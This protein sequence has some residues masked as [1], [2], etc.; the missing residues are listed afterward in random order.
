[1][2]FENPFLQPS[3]VRQSALKYLF[4]EEPS[5]TTITTGSQPSGSSSIVD[6]VFDISSS[7]DKISAIAAN[8]FQNGGEFNAEQGFDEANYDPV[9]ALNG[10]S[11]YGSIVKGAASFLGFGG[12]VSMGMSL[13]EQKAANDIDT[14]L[15]S[16]QG[17]TS[18]Q[19]N[20]TLSTIGAVG[21]VLGLPFINAGLGSNKDSV[22]NAKGLAS[23]FQTVDQLSGYISGT[24]P[25]IEAIVGNMFDDWSTITP[26]QYGTV[27]QEVSSYVQ[28]QVA[29]GKSLQEAQ[30]EAAN[31]YTP[32][33]SAPAGNNPDEIVTPPGSYDEIP[34]LL[35][36]SGSSTPTAPSTGSYWTDAAGNPIRSGDGGYVYS[37]S[38]TAA[39]RAAGAASPPTA[40]EVSFA[41]SGGYTAD[42]PSASAGGYDPTSGYD[43]DTDSGGGGS[44]GKI[45]C[46]A[47]NESYGFGSFRNRIWLAYAAK[48]LTKEHEKGYH[49]LFLPLVDIAYRK[50]TIISKPLRAVLENIARHRSADLRAEMRGSKRD[51]IGRVYR[52]ILEPLCYFVGKYK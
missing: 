47:M 13:A 42:V 15:Q 30:R 14:M 49:T 7:S 26:S 36:G 27:A 40:N 21:G 45:V 35:T 39:D 17:D 16:L 32:V 23:N 5:E 2:A 43:S 25:A 31:Y 18:G 4:S 29:S 6:N 46:T 51:T 50:Q 38:A 9:A 52:A 3:A 12:L 11:Q 8:I 48:H 33:A 41:E 37:G 19:S 20:L 34:G 28:N 44:S 10:L 22:A 1:M 24:D